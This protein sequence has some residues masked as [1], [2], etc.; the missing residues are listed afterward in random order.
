MFALRAR[1]TE[2]DAVDADEQI[3]SVWLRGPYNRGRMT[4][5]EAVDAYEQIL[6]VWLRR[7]YNAGRCTDDLNE[8]LQ[9]WALHNATR[10]LGCPTFEDCVREAA[11]VVQY[12]DRV[13]GYSA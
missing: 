8:A 1:M 6:S 4:E 2:S 10:K 13:R 11:R 3:L 12:T 9:G 7:P 5:S